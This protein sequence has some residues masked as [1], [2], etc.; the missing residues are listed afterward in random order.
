M[1]LVQWAT[2][3]DSA[4][5]VVFDIASDSEKNVYT[6]GYYANESINLY[7]AV[8]PS[9]QTFGP[10]TSLPT[11]SPPKITGFISRHNKDGVLNWTTRV[12]SDKSKVDDGIQISGVAVD[13]VDT[14]RVYI[15]G[16]RDNSLGDTHFYNSSGDLGITLPDSFGSGNSSFIACYSVSDTVGT[17]EWVAAMGDDT[18]IFDVWGI[19]TQDD[20]IFIS[21]KSN[22]SLSGIPFYDG[23]SETPSPLTLGTPAFSLDINENRSFVLACYSVA[24]PV[25]VFEWA[26]KV[27]MPGSLDESPDFHIIGDICV[28]S[29]GVFISGNQASSAISLDFYDVPVSSPSVPSMSLDLSSLTSPSSLMLAKYSLDGTL[30]WANVIDIKVEENKGMTQINISIDCDE[31]NVYIT[32]NLQ[33]SADF[34]DVVLPTDSPSALGSSILNL[35]DQN[36]GFILFPLDGFLACYSATGSLDGTFDWVALISG[37]LLPNAGMSGVK[38]SNNQICVSGTLATDPTTSP[39]TF[40]I[41]FYNAVTVAAPSPSPLPVLT[42]DGL[43]NYDGF[44]ACYDLDGV[45]QWT[46]LV[47]SIS[48]DAGFTIDIS[49]NCL[50]LAG[51]YFTPS[52]N[53]YDHASLTWP[54]I[55]LTYPL[56]TIDYNG[57]GDPMSDF[58][59]FL[60]QYRLVPP[61]TRPRCFTEDAVFELESGSDRPITELRPGDRIACQDGFATVVEVFKMAVYSEQN[62]IQFNPGSIGPGVPNKTL[63]M[64]PQHMIRHPNGWEA[65]CRK[66]INGT[67]VIKLRKPVKHFYHVHV[68]LPGLLTYAKVNGGVLADVWCNGNHNLK[69]IEKE[70]LIAL[71]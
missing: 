42:Q 70:E 40:P 12:E 66:A 7:D 69:K 23:I 1:A 3:F 56:I 36:T 29:D 33:N 52:T 37:E 39:T 25:A 46:T 50:Y 44:V 16:T 2:K 28:N 11:D 26:T 14:S 54:D 55:D 18:I 48:L 47:T 53:F 21:G 57:L 45:F 31:T 65:P 60:S 17:V 6:V 4:S 63:T 49:G 38:V 59:G 5:V 68:D 32:S 61:T 30:I 62:L 27:E 43:G 51:L 22:G 13:S 10:A 71:K 9:N 15:T 41:S 34:F 35:S 20:K 24:S 58:N 19:T 67:D 64:A 8:T